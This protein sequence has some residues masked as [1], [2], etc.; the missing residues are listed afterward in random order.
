MNIFLKYLLKSSVSKK[1]RSLLLIFTITISTSLLIGAM[2]ALNI[3]RGAYEEQAKKVWGDYNVLISA[4]K[5]N[6][7]PFFNKD[8]ISKEDFEAF[9]PGTK[10]RGYLSADETVNI[11]LGGVAAETY[12]K[13]PNMKILKENNLKPLVG[14]KAIISEKTSKA[15]NLGLGDKL[16]INIKGKERNLNICG[17]SENN[18][19]FFSDLKN[20]FS[21]IVN[22]NTVSDLWGINNLSNVMLVKLKKGVNSKEFV[23][24][25]NEKNSN[26]MA[27]ITLDKNG[28]DEDAKPVA[29][30]L[31]FMT[32]IVVLMSSFIIYSC[33]KL[34]IIE[35]M[36]VIGTFLSQGETRWGIIKLLLGESLIYGV[37]SGV[38]SMF[39][40]AGVIYLLADIVNKYKGY[41]VPTKADFN[42]K[43][44]VLGFSF[45]IG[46]S[47]ISAILPIIATRKL[48]IKDIILNK[49]SVSDKKSYKSFILGTMLI[50]IAIVIN[51]LDNS[52]SIKFSPI[53]FFLFIIGTVIAIPGIT[54]IITYPLMKIFENVSVFFKLALNNIRTSKILLNN[55]RL[56]VIGMISIMVIISLSSSYKNTMLGMAKS[57]KYDIS[58]Y[59]AMD[60][61]RIEPEDPTKIESTINKNVNIKKVIKIFAVR[62]GQIKVPNKNILIQGIEPQ[63]Y[64]YYDNYLEIKGKDEFY[65]ELDKNERNVAINDKVA[66]EIKKSKGDSII[67]RIN[68]KEVSYKITDIFNAKLSPDV[69]L[70]NKENLIKDF[71]IAL[72]T[73]YSL[74]INGNADEVKKALQKEFKGTLAQAKTFDEEVVESIGAISFFTKILLFFSV[75]T[76]IL[77]MLGMINNI[78]VSFIQRKREFVV[79]N[80][81]G[82]TNK[83]QR[84]M[85]LIEGVVTALLA[86]LLGG[87]ISYF[88]VNISNNLIKLVGLPLPIEYDFKAFFI[89]SIGIFIIMILSSIFVMVKNSRVSI[90]Q[91]LKYE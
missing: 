67:L 25:F 72:P 20:Q 18:G 56:I 15:Y 80:S 58:V 63:T 68:N 77:G 2:G 52:I 48:Q 53:V 35:R 64:K 33:F 57:Y 31:Y 40:G 70:I 87:I 76:V 29:A 39:L 55:I 5:T 46:I 47:L 28:I 62:D 38:L 88:A 66:K 61:T 84:R 82:M 60:P 45:S 43:Y 86:T 49:I 17:I 54:K 69:V 19:E 11:V 6:K 12:S 50:L 44:F 36:Q 30:F 23:K 1:G 75:M 32:L 65:R 37:V 51:N 27:K 34:I 79:L 10:V 41:G 22:E 78:G 83:Q 85:I 90:M 21:V 74:Q 89:I 14:D 9:V 59:Q 13:L 42:I 16:R 8:K 24:N 73:M 26:C 91:E 4:N 81:I 3:G 7:T 71:G